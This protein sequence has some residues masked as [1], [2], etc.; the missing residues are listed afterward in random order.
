MASRDRWRIGSRRL[1]ADS[2]AHLA[3]RSDD[4]LT[5]EFCPAS[6]RPLVR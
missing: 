6:S 1:H 2:T 3:S 4:A 5:N